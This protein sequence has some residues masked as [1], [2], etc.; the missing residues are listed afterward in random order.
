MNVRKIS[1]LYC[2]VVGLMMLVL[3]I[4]LLTTDSVPELHTEPIEMILILVA[5]FLTLGL[6]LASGYGLYTSKK[7]DYPV[8]LLALGS[9]YYS[10]LTNAGYTA[11]RGDIS[12]AALMFFFVIVNTILIYIT[13]KPLFIE[14]Q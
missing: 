13:Y 5:E 2:I 8:F 3:W 14:K 9:L 7:W 1:S 12:Q 11:Q 10:T 4:V 6:L